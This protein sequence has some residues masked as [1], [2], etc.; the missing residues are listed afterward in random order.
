MG[1]SQIRSM[2][3]QYM[4]CMYRLRKMNGRVLCD[5]HAL[6]LTDGGAVGTF[7]L[8]G[9]ALSCAWLGEQA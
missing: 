6:S 7:M 5:G 9:L 3:V 2:P 1:I 8:E 4:L